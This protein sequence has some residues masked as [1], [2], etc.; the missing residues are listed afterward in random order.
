M[1][2]KRQ[3]AMVKQVSKNIRKKERQEMNTEKK[4]DKMYSIM[5]KVQKALDE[6][7]KG[8]LSPKDYSFIIEYITTVMQCPITLYP[9][10]L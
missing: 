5:N 7:T 4:K 3:I 9:N 10:L 2:I 8:E 1:N 6:V